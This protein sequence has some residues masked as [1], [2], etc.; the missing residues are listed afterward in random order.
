[1]DNKWITKKPHFTPQHHWCRHCG[2][3]Y[4]Y[5]SGLSKHKKK[6]LNK[7]G[8]EN[9]RILFLEKEGEGVTSG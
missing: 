9:E 5:S 1:M 2:K 6:C 8:D 4:K 7:P 3:K